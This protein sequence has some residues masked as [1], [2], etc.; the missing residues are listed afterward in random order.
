[1][2]I[3]RDADAAAEIVMLVFAGDRRQAFEHSLQ[4]FKQKGLIFIYDDRGGC[5]FSLHIYPAVS[6]ASAGDDFFHIVGDVYELQTLTGPQVDD[7]VMRPDRGLTDL[8]NTCHLVHSLSCVTSSYAQRRRSK[9]NSL[10][11]RGRRGS[12]PP[13]DS[14][15]SP[16]R[17]APFQSGGI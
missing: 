10:S 6:D 4:I 14:G 13:Y 3:R 5:V 7:A 11:V 2:L 12:E 16:G 8:F 9:Q 15:I 17:G 1:W